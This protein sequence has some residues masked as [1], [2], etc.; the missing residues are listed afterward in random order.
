MKVNIEKTKCITFQKKNKVNKN[1]IF[2][3]GGYFVS[4]ICEFTYLG[5]TI[6]AACI[7]QKFNRI[8]KP[9]IQT[10]M[11]CFESKNQAKTYSSKHSFEAFRCMCNSNIIRWSRG[12]ECP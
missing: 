9:K 12:V 7:F 2:H 6:N 8:S 1:D 4:N 3:I 10:S 11:L 5:L